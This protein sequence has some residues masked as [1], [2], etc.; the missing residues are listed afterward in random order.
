MRYRYLLVDNDNTL[1]DFDAAE[2]RSLRAALE[3]VGKPCDDDVLARYHAINRDVWAALE[4]GETTQSE[5]KVERFR[6]LLAHYGWQEIDPAAL[7]MAFQ[8]QLC[9]CADLLPGAME[10]LQA[11][12]G[13]MKIALVTNG[14]SVTQRSRLS[15]CAFAHLLDAVIISEELGVSKPDPAMTQAALDALGCTDASQAVFLGDSHSSDVM[16]AVNAGVDAIWLTRHG[17]GESDKA[18]YIVESLEEA[19]ALLVR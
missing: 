9:T 18:T 13:R 12:H 16:A 8:D 6:R 17:R 10:L 2:R 14:V 1:M 3:G 15:R 19:A 11:V 4:R 7:A 5:L